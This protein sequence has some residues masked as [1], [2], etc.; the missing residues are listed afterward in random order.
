VAAKVTQVLDP[1][2]GTGIVIWDLWDYNP[3]VAESRR[4]ISPLVPTALPGNV[5]N[6]A[7]GR[8]IL[9]ENISDY[10]HEVKMSI[11]Y[12]PEN[13]IMAAIETVEQEIITCGIS[14]SL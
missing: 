4:C 7:P 11:L 13:S 1:L 9:R 5:L 8:Y 12:A 6:R 2:L 14:I 10:L 3:M